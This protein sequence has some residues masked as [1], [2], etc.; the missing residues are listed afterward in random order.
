MTTRPQQGRKTGT[1][2]GKSSQA[3]ESDRQ[4]LRTPELNHAINNKLLFASVDNIL[5]TRRFLY[6]QKEGSDNYVG[7]M[8]YKPTYRPTQAASIRLNRV[9]VGRSAG[10]AI[11]GTCR[12]RL[13]GHSS[14]SEIHHRLSHNGRHRSRPFHFSSLRPSGQP[15]PHSPAEDSHWLARRPRMAD[16]FLRIRSSIQPPDARQHPTLHEFR[17]VAGSM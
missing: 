15:A 6:C 4:A 12:R 8:P 11:H 10:S 16:G 5:L 1:C 3:R 13:D 9:W 7:L 14:D 2:D 17:D